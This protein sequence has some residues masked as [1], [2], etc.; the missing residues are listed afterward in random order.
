[1]LVEKDLWWSARPS[2]CLAWD[3]FK[4]FISGDSTTSGH[5]DPVSS[6]C[7]PGEAGS[8]DYSADVPC[9]NLLYPSPD[10]AEKSLALLYL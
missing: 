1:M 2:S 6:H 7:A 4:A 5:S 9:H 3:I 8:P 10:S